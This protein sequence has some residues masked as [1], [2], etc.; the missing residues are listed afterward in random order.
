M[1]AW[2]LASISVWWVP[3]YLALMVFIFVTPR[4]RRPGTK[5]P[6]ATPESANDGGS[7]FGQGLRADPGGGVGP[8]PHTV[9]P[10]S[11]TAAS[12]SIEPSGSNLDSLGLSP[13][14]PRRDRVRPRRTARSASEPLTGSPAVSWIQVGPGKFV[15][16][17]AGIQALE[18]VQPDEVAVVASA[19]TDVPDQLPPNS[20]IIADVPAA[21]EPL[22][23]VET[24][25]G[26]V[27]PVLGSDDGDPDAV[28]EEYGIAPSAFSPDPPFPSS[29]EALRPDSSEVIAKPETD[30]GSTAEFGG[31]LP[32]GAGG[33]EPFSSYPRMFRGRVAWTSPR[34]AHAIAGLDQASTRHD[35]RPGAKPRTSV[36]GWL[37]RNTC[38][39]QAARRAFGRIAHVERAWRPRSPPHLPGLC[40]RPVLPAG[41]RST[42]T[43]R[44]FRPVE[45]ANRSS[46]RRTRRSF[47]APNPVLSVHP[48][49]AR[50]VIRGPRP[51]RWRWSAESRRF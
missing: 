28:T 36:R 46:G 16:V 30:T 24:I 20:T 42:V 51:R 41:A 39:Q 31:I 1:T 10:G 47:P 22:N 48:Q 14:R 12:A 26:D 35:A 4:A 40:G 38:R 18:H 50:C 11:V 29:V 7:D 13:S 21:Q 8:H 34:I 5:P 44:G 32:P 43:E 45:S 6:K 49:S 3:A 17:E 9:E 25:A 19:E 37:T 15:R 2:A 33:A 23:A 27:G